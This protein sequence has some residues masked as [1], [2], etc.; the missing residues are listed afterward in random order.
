MLNFLVL[1]LIPGTNLQINFDMILDL[2]ITVVVILL[3]PR[4][5]RDLETRRLSSK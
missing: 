1:G 2:L 3:A 5:L 4:I